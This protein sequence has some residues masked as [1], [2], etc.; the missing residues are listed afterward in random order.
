MMNSRDNGWCCIGVHCFSSHHVLGLGGFT[1]DFSE[2]IDCRNFDSYGG[3]KDRE[4]KREE[5]REREREQMKP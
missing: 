5:E 1:Q 4:G 2:F 3:R